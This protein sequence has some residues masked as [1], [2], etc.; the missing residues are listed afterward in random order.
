MRGCRAGAV[1]I[2]SVGGRFVSGAW[3]PSRSGGVVDVYYI[4]LFFLVHDDRA[5]RS[6]R[7]RLNQGRLRSAG[8]AVRRRLVLSPH[9][10]T[11]DPSPARGEGR[12]IG[13]TEA[14]DF[15][16]PPTPTLPHKEG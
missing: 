15:A 12:K 5:R 3:C 13:A 16:S 2:C 1:G 8:T 14:Y 4:H 11:P 10:L 6:V 9:P 7:Q